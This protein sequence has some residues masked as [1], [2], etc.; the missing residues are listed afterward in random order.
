MCHKWLP[1]LLTLTQ[2]LLHISCHNSICFTS[3]PNIAFKCKLLTSGT[4]TK[5][6]N[7]TLQAL[8]GFLHFFTAEEPF[9]WELCSA[10]RRALIYFQL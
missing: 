5:I 9:Y 2:L 1:F 3:I 10:V 4:E 8:K 6:E 7:I